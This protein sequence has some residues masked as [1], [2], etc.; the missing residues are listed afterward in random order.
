M[1]IFINRRGDLDKKE[2]KGIPITKQMILECSQC[3][4]LEQVSTIILRDKNI[5]VF[6]QPL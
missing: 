1:E 3:D 4:E 5:S 2:K 6:D